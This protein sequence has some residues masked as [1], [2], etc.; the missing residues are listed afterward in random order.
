[1]YATTSTLVQ[2][3]DVLLVPFVQSF[4]RDRRVRFTSEH[5]EFY[6]Y[7]ERVHPAHCVAVSWKAAI[8]SAY[9]FWHVCVFDLDA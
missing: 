6:I 2:V 8:L 5:L 9:S 1:M 3:L 7:D 4:H